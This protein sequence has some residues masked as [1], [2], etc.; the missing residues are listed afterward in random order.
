LTPNMSEFEQVVGVCHTD[1]E[2]VE[3]GTQLVKDLALDALLITR[4]ERG[5]SLLQA[6]EAPL[7]LPTQAQEVYDVT[8][9][10]DTVIGVLATA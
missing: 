6:N 1:D 9:A 7:H 2:L 4:S 10:G 8:G 5:M 3:K